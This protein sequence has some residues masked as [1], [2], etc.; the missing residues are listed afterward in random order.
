MAVKGALTTTFGVSDAAVPANINE[1]SY[2]LIAFTDCGEV[3]SLGEFGREYNVVSVVNLAEGATRKF[4]GSYNNGTVQVDLL[5]DSADAGQS[6]LEDGAQET[7]TYLFKIGL[8]GASPDGEEFYF[9]GL[10]TMLKRIVG[11][12]DDAIMLRA[13]IEIDHRNIIEG[14]N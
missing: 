12:P 14:T 5:F 6:L 4:K 2:D 9:S 8:P 7:A 3:V 10:V 1:A 13:T 11:G